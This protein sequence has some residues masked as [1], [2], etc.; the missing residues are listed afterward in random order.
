[1][2]ETSKACHKEVIMISLQWVKEVFLEL[3]N[4]LEEKLPVDQINKPVLSSPIG[5]LPIVY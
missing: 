1:M 5:P 4:I 2:Q 3:I